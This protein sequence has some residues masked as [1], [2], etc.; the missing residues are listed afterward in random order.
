[1]NNK[2]KDTKENQEQNIDL[3]NII[4]YILSHKKSLVISF[5]IS[6]LFGYLILF[7]SKP[8]YETTALIQVE[9]KTGNN[10]LTDLSDVIPEKHL[11][12]LKRLRY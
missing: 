10:I 2:I 7:Y 1:M 6:L 11:R 12:L 9:T 3:L 5:L 8:I 4:F